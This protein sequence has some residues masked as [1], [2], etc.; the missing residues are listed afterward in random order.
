[1]T[2]TKTNDEHKHCTIFI[3]HSIWVR[4]DG[5][6]FGEAPSPL[7][8]PLFSCSGTD[9]RL[10]REF[11]SR[12][13]FRALS[14]SLLY[15][16]FLQIRRKKAAN[17][18]VVNRYQHS[19]RYRSRQLSSLSTRWDGRI[20]VNGCIKGDAADS[21][22]WESWRKSDSRWR[23]LL[24]AADVRCRLRWYWNDGRSLLRRNHYVENQLRKMATEC[25]CAPAF[26]VP[27]V[28]S[29]FRRL[30]NDR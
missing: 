9:P 29:F 13:D 17:E 30:I 26:H 2:M 12:S 23:E 28:R 6:T 22:K 5:Q 10:I 14:K 3:W 11:L 7:E 1:M 27:T 18:M 24:A 8:Q 15:N 20:E 21:P 16:S 4:G 19:A 25:R